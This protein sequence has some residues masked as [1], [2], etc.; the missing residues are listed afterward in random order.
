[1]GK[2]KTADQRAKD[3]GVVLSANNL[4]NLTKIVRSTPNVFSFNLLDNK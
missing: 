2:V 4:F 3:M 1:M